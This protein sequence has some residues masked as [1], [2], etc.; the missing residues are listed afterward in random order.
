[1]HPKGE[2]RRPRWASK[3]HSVVATLYPATA[4]YDA[5]LDDGHP[6]PVESDRVSLL[7]ESVLAITG[8]PSLKGRTGRQRI[9]SPHSIVHA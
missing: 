8:R 4:N 9:H 6:R 1:M 3:Y 7:A 2:L 5:S